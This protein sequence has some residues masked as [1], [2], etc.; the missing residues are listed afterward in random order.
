MWKNLINTK[1]VKQKRVIKVFP[2]STS[3]IRRATRVDSITYKA[4]EKEI[5]REIHDH[6]KLYF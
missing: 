1:E 4:V 6:V 3:S 2:L 5:E